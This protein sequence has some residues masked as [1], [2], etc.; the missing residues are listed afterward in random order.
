LVINP[1]A[2]AYNTGKLTLDGNAGDA[3]IAPL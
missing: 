2:T 3:P 1:A